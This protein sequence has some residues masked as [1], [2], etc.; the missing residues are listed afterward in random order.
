MFHLLFSEM[1]LEKLNAV[2][3]GQ[4]QRTCKALKELVPDQLY[5]IENIRKAN[6]KFGEKVIVDLKDDIYCYLPER[7][8]K[9]LL[10]EDEAG[11]VEFK[12]QL[13]RSEISIRRL[14]GRW[15]PVEF[16]ISLPDEDFGALENVEGINNQA[17]A[18]N[19]AG[20]PAE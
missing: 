13:K 6:T 4:N 8:S 19:A 12:E 7:V 2:G 17:Q 3:R 20:G 5:E 9:Q 10:F 1:N 18:E 11:F 16:V 15:N 14:K